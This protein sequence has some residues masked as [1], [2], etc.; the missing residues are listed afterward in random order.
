MAD[1]VKISP[2]YDEEEDVKAP[3]HV[4]D[5][6]VQDRPSDERR[7]GKE[8]RASERRAAGFFRQHPNAKWIL[9]VVLVLI[10]VGVAF[11]WHYYS[12]RE[13]TDDAQIDGHI[14]PI[15]AR[16]TGTAIQV[17]HDDNEFVQAG[18]LLVELDPKDYQVAVDRARADLANAQAN[19]V[20][21]HVGVPL[22]KTTSSSQLTAADAAVKSAQRDIESAQARLNEAQANYTKASSDLKRMEMLVAKDEISHQQY[23]AAVAANNSAKATVDAANATIAAAESRAAQAQAQAEAVRTVPE[24]LRVTEARAGAAAAEVQRAISALAQAELNLKYTKIYAPVT[25]IL[26]KRSVE[27]GQVVQAGQ[28]LFSI[29]NLDD[30]W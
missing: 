20:A 18:T 5:R 16:V 22:T 2:Q 3:V 30:I 11:V 25:G 1:P 26:S 29:V 8:R 27:P 15:S 12:I 17:L 23:D 6:P 13:S 9:L 28:P 7:A 19:A 21:A 4:D 10:L 24:Q 14:D